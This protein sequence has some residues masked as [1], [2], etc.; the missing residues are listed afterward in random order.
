MMDG[1]IAEGRAYDASLSIHLR[2]LGHWVSQI[3]TQA[4]WKGREALVHGLVTV[5]QGNTLLTLYRQQRR[6]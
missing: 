3:W 1:E 6:G 2:A 4:G 5:L